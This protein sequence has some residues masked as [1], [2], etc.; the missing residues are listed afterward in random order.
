MNSEKKLHQIIKDDAGKEEVDICKALEDLYEEGM[1]KGIEKLILKK[2]NKG[3][4][5]QDIA[6]FVELS[7]EE[8]EDIIKQQN[9]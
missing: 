4:S 2:H 5:V 9:V 7:A 6:D 3:M 1:G 8:V